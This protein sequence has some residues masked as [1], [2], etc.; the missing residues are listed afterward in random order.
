VKPEAIRTT[1]R[2]PLQTHSLDL[3]RSLKLRDLWEIAFRLTKGRYPDYE[4]QHQNTRVSASE[5]TTVG[6]MINVNHEVFV[7]PIEA[8]ATTAS[9]ADQSTEELCLVKVY[10]D[11]YDETVVSYWEPRTTTKSLASAVFRYYRQKFTLRPSTSVE[12]LSTFWTKLYHTGDNHRTGTTIEAHWEPI[13]Q[14]FNRGYCTGTLMTESCVDNEDPDE[15][16]AP[17]N[18]NQPLVFKLRLGKPPRCQKTQNNTLSRLDVLKQKFD[19]YINR[20][21]AYNF[22]THIGL[23][24][25]SNKPSVSQRITHAIENFRHKLNNMV[26]SGDTSVWDSIAL[27]QDQLQQYAKQY[28]N[29]KLR[30]I[31]ISDGEDNKSTNRP[32]DLA[33]RLSYKRIVVDSFCL[34]SAQN[35]DLKTFS[36]LCG[37]YTFEPKTLDEAM[38]IC[39]MEPVLS[40]LERPSMSPEDESDDDSDEDYDMDFDE[41]SLNH[42][43]KKFHLS[44]S[45]Q[46]PRSF[47]GGRRGAC[48]SRHLP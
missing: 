3:P 40:I 46:L 8:T 33:M 42:Y 28:P 36:Y 38:A 23:L 9:N 7:M 16:D 24:T 19:A 2:S 1:F 10:G 32:A 4:L 6:R 25:F 30:I 41:P 45:L 13:S 11:A 29:A 26:A 39:E 35:K 43:R 34:G 27:A 22:Q 20:L 14:Y 44:P 17:I 47:L 37:G 5:D 12:K 31:R 15:A 48:D 18:T 21:L